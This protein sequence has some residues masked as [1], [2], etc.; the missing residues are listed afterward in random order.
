MEGFL[1]FSPLNNLCIYIS[2]IFF[3]HSS[4]NGQLGCFH[5]LAVVKDAAVYRGCRCLF[6]IAC[7]FLS[8]KYPEVASLDHMGVL[9]LVFWEAS[10]L[11]PTV[12]P[13]ICIPTNG[14]FPFP[15][16][17]TDTCQVIPHCGFDLYFPDD[18]WCWVPFHGLLAICRS[19]LEKISIQ[20][21]SPFLNWIVWGF[22]P[23]HLFFYCLFWLPWDIWN[24]W[25][26]DQIQAAVVT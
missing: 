21:L 23:T 4:V 3:T 15:H 6:A 20:F 10:I 18:W 2:H 1:S 5:V 13:P 17:F 11:F 9:L 8:D 22:G 16:I 25:A 12:A 14:A 7:P 24:S 19:S 26:R